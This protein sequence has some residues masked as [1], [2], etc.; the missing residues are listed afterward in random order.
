MPQIFVGGPGGGTDRTDRGFF[1][2]E[3]YKACIPFR[4]LFDLVNH[5][6]CIDCAFRPAGSGKVNPVCALSPLELPQLILG[7]E[8]LA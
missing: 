3:K 1:N 5:Q 4:R 2:P 8:P 7:L 6:H